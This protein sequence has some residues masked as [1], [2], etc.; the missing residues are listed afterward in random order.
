MLGRL[1]HLQKNGWGGT[2]TVSQHTCTFSCGKATPRLRD[3]ALLTESTPAGA[4]TDGK[5]RF[6]SQVGGYIGDAGYKYHACT[7]TGAETEDLVAIRG[8]S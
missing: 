8:Q 3:M 7:E 5:A 6:L 1:S 2:K 4:D